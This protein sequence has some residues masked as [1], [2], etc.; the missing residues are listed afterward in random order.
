M[1][2]LIKHILFSRNISKN[3]STIISL[4]QR[5]GRVLRGAKRKPYHIV[6]FVLKLM[7]TTV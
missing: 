7:I 2:Q 5:Q 6:Y 3:N 4:I 1:L